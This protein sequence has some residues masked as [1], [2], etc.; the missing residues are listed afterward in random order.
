LY[1]QYQDVSNRD[2][3][4]HIL[5]LCWQQVMVKLDGRDI[6]Y[7]KTMKD[8]SITGTCKKLF[9]G[10]GCTDPNT[11]NIFYKAFQ[12]GAL[13]PAVG[14]FTVEHPDQIQAGRIEVECQAVV[15]LCRK[16]A[17]TRDVEW[18]ADNANK[19]LPEGELMMQ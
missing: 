19:K 6:G 9:E 4:F 18:A 8:R 11:G 5:V 15:K 12:F 16:A 13:T 7:T 3:G 2:V 17:T 14:A 10:F 1:L